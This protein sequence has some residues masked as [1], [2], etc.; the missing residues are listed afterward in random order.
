ML[1]VVSIL[2]LLAACGQKG[3]LKLPD[4]AKAA[5]PPAS[6]ASASALQ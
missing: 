1:V 4:K 6:A 5:S 3:P 2:G